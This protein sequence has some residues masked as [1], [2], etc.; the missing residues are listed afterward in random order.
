MT[1]QPQWSFLEGLFVA[2]CGG[3]SIWLMIWIVVAW[4]TLP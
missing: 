1:P 2:L 4:F 3:S